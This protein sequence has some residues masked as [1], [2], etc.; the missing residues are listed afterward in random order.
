[1]KD[2]EINYMYIVKHFLKK[3]CALAGRGSGV[4]M[5]TVLALFLPHFSNP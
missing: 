1:V 2:Y 5:I 4:D 3:S